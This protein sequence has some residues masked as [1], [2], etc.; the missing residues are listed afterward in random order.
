MNFDVAERL[1]PNG[2]RRAL[3]VA[4][5][6]WRPRPFSALKSEIGNLGTDAPFVSRA[7][8]AQNQAPH[9]MEAIIIDG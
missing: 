9:K 6:P 4:D 7:K 3:L 2:G 8:Q 5:P 1:L